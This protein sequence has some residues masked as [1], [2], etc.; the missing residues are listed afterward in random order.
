MTWLRR[1]RWWLVAL[2]P[3]LLLA[4][5]A[6]S[7]RLTAVYLP[8]EWSRP[9]EAGGP[10]GTLQQTYAGHDAARHQR[11]VT[12]EVL[13]VTAVPSFDGHAAIDG[14]TLWQIDLRLSAAPDQHLTHCEI[15]LVDGEG[16]RY[17]FQGGRRAADPDDTFYSA[18]VVAPQCVPE[19]APGPSLNPITGEPVE[20]PQVRPDS[21]EVTTALVMP[22]GY[23]PEQVRIAWDTPTYLVLDIP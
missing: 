21:W 1:N 8:W 20:S 2:I 13:G 11:T 5:L 17:G 19:D 14:A 16:T 10:V 4:M 12:V 3:A 23:E 7:F 22:E 6:S 18:L 15:E 9:I